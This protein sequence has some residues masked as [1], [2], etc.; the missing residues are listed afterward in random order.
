MVQ[1]KYPYRYICWGLNIGSELECPELPVSSNEADVFIHLG[2]TPQRLPEVKSRGVYYEMNHDQ[3]LLTVDGVARYWVRSGREI[4]IEPLAAADNSAIRLYLLGSAFGAL[5]F[6]RGLVPFHG[7]ALDINGRAVVIAGR[8]AAGKSTLAAVLCRR[9]HRLLADDVCVFQLDAG[10]R[11]FVL[12]AYPRLKL[13][14]DVVDAL[15]QDKQGLVQVRPGL[16]KYVVPLDSAFC[17]HPLLLAAVYIL[18]PF[19]D[20][21]LEFEPITGQDKFNALNRNTYRL[22]FTK[23]LPDKSAHYKACL[24]VSQH[25]RVA[26]IH[27][28]DALV[29]LDK[30][31]DLVEEESSK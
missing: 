8:S 22:R 28:P 20:D 12:P 30:L 13:W 6:Q 19:N 31:A 16:E 5:L 18:S 10:G 27:R 17:P 23:G 21:S 11:P 14:A 24:A 25:A 4:I 1:I 2:Q 3:F 26:R 29:G 7:S 15:G 9:G